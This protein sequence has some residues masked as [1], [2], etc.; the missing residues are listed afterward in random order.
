MLEA[1]HNRH[2]FALRHD[3][4]WERISIAV[5]LNEVKFEVLCEIGEHDF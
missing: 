4:D 2:C 1:E 5:W 3:G